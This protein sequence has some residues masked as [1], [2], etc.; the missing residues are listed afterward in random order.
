MYGL[1]I[2][3]QG[4]GSCDLP[5]NG[6]AELTR[7][8]TIGR[9]G[10]NSVV[11]Q[12]A[13]GT[14][15]KHHCTITAV[16]GKCV[17]VDHSRNG[18]FV[19]ASRQALDRESAVALEAGDV[20]QIGAYALTVV[21]MSEPEGPE[22]GDR[23]EISELNVEPLS[24]Q[25]L[26]GAVMRPRSDALRPFGAQMPAAFFE[27]AIGIAPATFG[28][29]SI[30]SEDSLMLSPVDRHTG[31]FS[32]AN[33]EP[34]EA[35]GMAYVQPR[36]STEPIPDDWDLMADLGRTSVTLD[37]NPAR[38]IATG[39]GAEGSDGET[40]SVPPVAKPPDPDVAA[41]VAAFFQGCGVDDHE[42][43]PRDFAA[44][45]RRAGQALRVT[46]LNLQRVFAH[47]EPASLSQILDRPQ[48]NP[49]ALEADPGDVLLSLLATS[50]AGLPGADDVIERAFGE[51]RRKRI[52]SEVEARHSM[53]RMLERLAPATIEKNEHADDLIH[54]H[55]S[56]LQH[57][58]CW[59]RYQA[60]YREVISDIEARA[61][62]RKEP[63]PHASGEP[64]GPKSQPRGTDA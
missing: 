1:R 22:V 32:I 16:D 38:T 47:E 26:L 7:K 24:E 54:R 19:N 34:A 9:G 13:T 41:A 57:A 20:L 11:L 29:M 4:G 58:R 44:I 15:S 60:S 36:L 2:E 48:A 49:L 21:A 18:T 17:V 28:D 33:R 42:I 46:V 59:R 45:L 5:A 61:T 53:R 56:V 3:Y 6:W 39:E 64:S 27:P 50:L 12:D 40:L 23:L 51:M 43:D 63:P 62:G 31:I 52:S 10:D 8:L 14:I 35:V 37:H 30:T 25:S 55:L